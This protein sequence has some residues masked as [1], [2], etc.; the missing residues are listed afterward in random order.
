MSEI[1]LLGTQT[2]DMGFLRRVHSVTLRYKVHIW[3]SKALDVE[4]LLRSDYR[5]IPVR[6]F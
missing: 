3:I 6:M 2:A 5:G 1:V 4:P